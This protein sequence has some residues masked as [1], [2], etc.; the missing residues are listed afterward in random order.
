MHSSTVSAALA[1]LLTTANAAIVLG[2]SANGGTYAWL[3]SQGACNAQ[4]LDP[5]CNTDFRVPAGGA[6]FQLIGCNDATP[7]VPQYNTRNGNRDA[8]CTP[9]NDGGNC[10]D[11]DGVVLSSYTA[12]TVC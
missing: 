5:I 10:Y 1:L 4:Y 3:Q 2:V 6:V 7:N 8:N 9:S 12:Y 11:V